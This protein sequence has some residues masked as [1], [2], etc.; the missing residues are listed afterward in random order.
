METTEWEESVY[1]DSEGWSGIMVLSDSTVDSVK[2][3]RLTV[4][5]SDADGGTL[6]QLELPAALR[7]EG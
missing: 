1:V 5:R 7:G 2:I 6:K 4:S 3:F